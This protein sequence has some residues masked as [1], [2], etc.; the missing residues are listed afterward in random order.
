MWR[1]GRGSSASR[2]FAGRQRRFSGSG[3][4]R[5]RRRGNPGRSNGRGR[6][7]WN[8]RGGGPKK[9]KLPRKPQGPSHK[10]LTKNLRTAAN[11]VTIGTGDATG[12][13]KALDEARKW[14]LLVLDGKTV[15]QI[16]VELCR[17]GLLEVAVDVVKMLKSTDSLSP[18]GTTKIL[19]AMPASVPIEPIVGADFVTTLVQ[20]TSF[21][22]GAACKEYFHSR[23]RW[24][25]LEY[26]QET[27]D[28]REKMNRIPVNVLV[29]MG[30]CAIAD[31]AEQAK[32]D[33]SV[34][35][36]T[37]RSSSGVEEGRRGLTG[38]DLVLIRRLPPPGTSAAPTLSTTEGSQNEFCAEATVEISSP[39][40]CTPVLKAKVKAILQKFADPT[41][42]SAASNAGARPG[43]DRSQSQ[44]RIDKLGNQI[45][46]QRQL[47]AI[48]VLTSVTTDRAVN[49]AKLTQ[50]KKAGG[51]T[52]PRPANEIAL[53]ITESCLVPRGDDSSGI[54]STIPKPSIPAL[55]EA[56]CLDRF[57]T[58]MR[59]PLAAGG[60]GFSSLRDLNRSQLAAVNAA[61]TRRL[62]LIQGPPGTGKTQVSVRL[63]QHW[64][65]SRAHDTT[66]G[67][68]R[69]CILACS[70]SNIAVDNILLGLVKRGV[71]AV[72]LGR[73]ENTRP[74]LLP[75]CVDEITGVM[76]EQKARS[77]EGYTKQD[78]HLAKMRVL[79][80]AQVICA[81][82][83]GAGSQ[84]LDKMRF[85]AVLI[86]EAGQA[87]ELSTIVPLTRGCQQMVLVGDHYQLPPTVT[88]DDAK[89]EGICVSLFERLARC[90]VKTE[91]LDTQY[92]MHPAI[93]GFA[94]DCFYAGRIKDGITARDRPAPRGFRWPHASFPVAFL[95]V[96]NG[97]EQEDAGS[98]SK[99][100]P[101]EAELV[102]QIVEDLVR[103][104]RVPAS[105]VGIVTPY[106]AQVRALR[107]M[108]DRAGLREV[109]CASVDG[110]QGREKHVIVIS[111][112]RANRN[113]SVGFLKDWCRCNVAVTR[114]RNGLIVVGNER[115]LRSEHRSWE[116]WLDYV[117]A[118]GCAVGHP[119]RG[120]YDQMRIRSMA[121]GEGRY[122][123]FEVMRLGAPSSNVGRFSSSTESN[124]LQLT[125]AAPGV[126]AP[127]S[128]V[129]ST[130]HVA[131]RPPSVSPV[132]PHSRFQEYASGSRY[133]DNGDA[134]VQ[135][136]RMRVSGPIAAN[137]PGFSLSNAHK[138]AEA[139]AG[140]AFASSSA[141]SSDTS[142]STAEIQL[143]HH[144]SDARR[145]DRD[146]S[147]SRSRS[148]ERSR[149]RGG[150]ASRSR[151][152]SRSR[153]RH[154]HRRRHRHRH[155][156]SSS[157]ESERTRR[158]RRSASR[159]HEGD[160]ERRH[161]SSRR[162][163]RRSDS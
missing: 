160:N 76:L 159:S 146:R 28:A 32:K 18:A 27:K 40:I 88:S 30:H 97:A 82:C 64:V 77:S 63:L 99:C 13:M 15:Q 156:S 154:R 17:S 104:G 137:A 75:H 130:Q 12:V 87:T 34:I 26:L 89:R 59:G 51:K 161:H 70:D 73:P 124:P 90:G 84:V 153:H 42:Q 81:T 39:L 120:T 3:R 105:E 20:R 114:A 91:L 109:E 49:G 94:S 157:R 128:G 129:G 65:R 29:R 44:W 142:R 106:A 37:A 4:G 50:T 46:Y 108:R 117:F 135:Q 9:R 56:P 86:D 68:A 93:S 141:N 35:F 144:Q 54:A 127:R 143:Q 47:R 31:W 132:P 101:A 96:P 22:G 24:V 131:T 43:S 123:D 149:K 16:A 58:P 1:G 79:N 21:A 19:S 145:R 113:G 66:V 7:R 61:T 133:S 67:G 11:A 119:A 41:S 8:R 163:D 152:R 92:R 95:D 52:D 69:G 72:R 162:R 103:Y 60:Y 48:S 107:R 62:T 122:S 134:S 155:R 74:E 5:G 147:R 2:G 150:S 121:T 118:N 110:F 71:R 57:G 125:G 25:V 136:K 55:C 100:N 116:P 102:M 6:G 14:G 10:K 138:H 148:R 85:A 78:K 83:I 126:L 115:T 140:A 36:R 80:R 23:C 33:N 151:S 53:A 112:V 111:T 158:R 45:Q 38:G 98:G 139:T